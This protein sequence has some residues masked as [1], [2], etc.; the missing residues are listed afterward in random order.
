M[1]LFFWLHLYCSNFG[2]GFGSGLD[3]DSVTL[4]IRIQGQ[5]NVGVF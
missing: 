4:L 3:P 1:G 2:Y 5:E